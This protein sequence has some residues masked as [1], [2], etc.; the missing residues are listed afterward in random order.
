MTYRDYMKE[1]P[2]K[3]MSDI[4]DGCTPYVYGKTTLLIGDTGAIERVIINGAPLDQSE[5]PQ[6]RLNQ[7]ELWRKIVA[8]TGLFD[9]ARKENPEDYAGDT[10]DDLDWYDVQNIFFD[11]V[12]HVGCVSCPWFKNCEYMDYEF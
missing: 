9:E 4:Q 10:I 1:H 2:N 7:G 5:I 6:G 3:A 8:D 12:H 11:S